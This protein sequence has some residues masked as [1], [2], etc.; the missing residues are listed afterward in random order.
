MDNFASN[1]LGRGYGCS[2]ASIFV[3]TGENEMANA[4]KNQGF[5]EILRN[6]GPDAT[7]TFDST[8]SNPTEQASS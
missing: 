5:D 1:G 3:E 6:I 4:L 2:V 7:A 8:A